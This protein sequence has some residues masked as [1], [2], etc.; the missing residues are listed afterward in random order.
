VTINEE[1]RSPGAPI[2]H[3]RH[4]SDPAINADPFRGWIDLLH[5]Y[6]AFG[7]D[8]GGAPVWVVLRYDD[9]CRVMRDTTTFSRRYTDAYRNPVGDPLIPIHLD[10]PEHGKYRRLINPLLS[11]PVAKGLEPKI[12]HRCIELVDSFV[13]NGRVEVLHDFAFRFAPSVFLGLMGLPQEQAEEFLGLVQTML[14]ETD[15]TD[16]GAVRRIQA[17]QETNDF[18]AGVIADRRAVPKED[19]V[20]YLVHSEVDGAP[21]EMETLQSMC[22]LLFEAGQ[23]TVASTLGSAFYYLASHP[24]HRRDLVEHPEIVPSAVEEILRYF[25]IDTSIRYVAEETELAGCP[26]KPG[27]R[28]VL[29]LTAANRD[30]SQ[31]PD[32]DAFDLRRDPNRHIGFG[33]GPHRCAGSHL[34]RVE[35]AIALEEWHRRIPEYEVEPGFEPRY[36][37]GTTVFRLDALPLVWG[38]S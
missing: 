6:D 11:P 37:I 15:A 30:E 25:P 3:F 23:H 35:L 34:A 38:A 24:E 9:I 16:P 10:P 29:P 32:A 33:V 13:E 4:D 31:F 19:Y 7:S 1:R 12:R 36:I 14:D 8:Q 17:R 27:D 20:S 5:R 2:L 21:I 28:V 18:F 26:M 22:L